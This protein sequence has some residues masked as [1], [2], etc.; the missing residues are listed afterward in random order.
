MNA[1]LRWDRDGADWPNR[2]ASRF[3]TAAGLRWHVQTM[4]AGP[5]LLLL[6]GTG[7]STHSFRDLMPLLARHFAVVAPD[8]PG[9]GFTSAPPSAAGYTLLGMARSVAGLL[10]AL[11]SSPV[12][13][14][15]HSAGAPI[16][17]R[18]T[19]DGLIAP[20]GLV[21][22]NAAILPLRGASTEFFAP[23]AK[24]MVR[25]PLVPRA[26]AWRAGEAATV[27]RLID[28]TGSRIDPAGL[29]FYRRL[30]G[31]PAHVAGALGMMANWELRPMVAEL[32]RLASPLLLIVGENDRAIP[33]ADARVIRTMLPATRVESMPGLG[34]LAHEEQPDRTAALIEAFAREIGV[35]AA[36]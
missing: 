33:P 19:L 1:A 23:L 4:G 20:A 16:L 13:A 8:L 25:L 24:L 21:G 10:R 29:E 14:A 27:A 6:H 15:G 36:A 5:P 28:G 12:L 17:V 9:H 2:D 26:F 22:L 34:H 35:L 31:S 7:A 3:V 11:G 30:A 32:K 18:M